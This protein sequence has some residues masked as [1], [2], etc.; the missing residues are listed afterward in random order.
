MAAMALELGDTEGA[1]RYG[2]EAEKRKNLES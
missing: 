2:R 1:R